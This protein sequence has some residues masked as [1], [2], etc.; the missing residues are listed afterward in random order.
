M[1]ALPYSLL[2]IGG[3]ENVALKPRS[4]DLASFQAALS[5]HT[6]PLFPLF[7]LA[8]ILKHQ[9]AQSKNML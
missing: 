7:C 1:L 6:C 9:K 4:L 8:N 5:I 2:C 3:I